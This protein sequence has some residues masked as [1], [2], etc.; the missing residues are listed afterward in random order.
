MRRLGR[1]PKWVEFPLLTI[2][3]A[4]AVIGVA[5]FVGGESKAPAVGLVRAPAESPALETVPLRS[6]RGEGIVLDQPTTTSPVLDRQAIEALVLQRWPG[7]TIRESVLASFERR[8]LRVNPGRDVWL[9]SIVPA[10]GFAPNITGEV[11]ATFYVVL[12][13]ATTGNTIVAWEGA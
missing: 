11:V 6:L 10:N 8:A 7:A 9:V 12:L 1:I 5:S 4:I 13:D 2:G 3:V